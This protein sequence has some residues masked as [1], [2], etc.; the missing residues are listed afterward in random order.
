MRM[1][2]W[3]I[4]W[5]DAYSLRFH[6][7]MFRRCL[8]KHNELWKKPATILKRRAEDRSK[9]RKKECRKQKSGH[10]DRCKLRGHETVTYVHILE[11]KQNTNVKFHCCYCCVTA[12]AMKLKLYFQELF[13]S[14]Y[15][16]HFKTINCALT[17]QANNNNNKNTKTKPD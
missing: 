14:E 16:G 13:I 2:A 17:L 10:T 1:I 6:F 12:C 9:Q 8:K 7:I 3:S 15:E 5:D 4:C 11:E